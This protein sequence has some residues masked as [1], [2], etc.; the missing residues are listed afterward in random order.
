MWKKKREK[1]KKKRRK[2]T[3]KKRKRSYVMIIIDYIRI[4]SMG[5]IIDR[6][7]LL[8]SGQKLFDY[9]SETISVDELSYVI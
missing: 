1:N 6:D 7:D 5:S 8:R 3:K 9:I 4:F 2:K